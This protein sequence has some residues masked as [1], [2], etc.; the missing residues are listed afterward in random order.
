MYDN[1]VLS[2]LFPVTPPKRKVFI[3]Y[4][5]KEQAWVDS[6]RTT[7]SGEYDLF[8]D[9]SLDQ[10]IDSSNLLYINRTIR[11]DYITGSSI[12][13]VICGADTWRRKCVDWEIYSTLDKDHAL[14]GLTLP[15]NREWRNGQYV[16]IVPDRL[17]VNIEAGYAHWADLP[18]DAAN[19]KLAIEHALAL[20]NQNKLYK[21]NSATKMTRNR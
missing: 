16:R 10:A 15:H 7:F 12:T 20:S 3:S 14:L 17:H 4:H 1:S 2:A 5:H 13:I 11:E 9:C 6:F 21:N 19:L 8:T 18:I